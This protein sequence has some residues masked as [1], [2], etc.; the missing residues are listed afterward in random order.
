ILIT[1]DECLF[2]SN[3]DRPIIWAPLDKS[4]LRKKGQ[5]KFIMISDFLLE[6]IGKLKLTEQNS[7][8]NPNT[9]SEAR[10]Y[11]NPGKNEKSWW[12]SKHLIDQVI[13]YTIPIFEILYP[14]AVV[15]FTFDNSTNH[16]A[17]VKD[18]LNVI[19]MNVNPEEKQ[20]LMKSIFF[21][22]NKTF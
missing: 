13:N 9:P 17:M 6:T 5:G 14:N 18:V 15:V 3:D 19:N 1:Y 11:L 7:L 10:K 21:G 22:L 8:L 12:T 16:G 2:Y 20:V 4:S